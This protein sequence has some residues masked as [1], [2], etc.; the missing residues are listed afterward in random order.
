MK[1]VIERRRAVYGI[2]LSK[3]KDVETWHKERSQDY[4]DDHR[5]Y[6]EAYVEKL[7]GH[8][9]KDVMSYGR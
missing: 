6:A 3:I 4:N 7:L 9:W 8:N 5:L 2:N 1:Q